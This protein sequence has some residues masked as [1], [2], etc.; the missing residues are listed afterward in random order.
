MGGLAVELAEFRLRVRMANI[1]QRGINQQP[2]SRSLSS[3]VERAPAGRPT[4]R[5]ARDSYACKLCGQA[6]SHYTAFCWVPTSPMSGTPPTML[7]INC[8][9]AG[10]QDSQCK[11]QDPPPSV[12]KLCNIPGAN[13]RDNDDD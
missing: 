2:P 6:G 12:C 5:R 7:C 10:H 11:V 3:I 13:R 1:F 9:S 8:C 4:Q